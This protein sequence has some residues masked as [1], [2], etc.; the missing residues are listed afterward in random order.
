ME[1]IFTRKEFPYET[2]PLTEKVRDSIAIIVNVIIN[3]K[4]TT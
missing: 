3:I 4:N 1:R 2:T